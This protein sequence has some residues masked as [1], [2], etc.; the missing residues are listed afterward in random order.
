MC[1]QALPDLH[2]A[3][4]TDHE[5]RSIKYR[6]RSQQLTKA[7]ERYTREISSKKKSG[8]REI[9]AI[10]WWQASSLAP[11]FLA[12]LRG[13]D[14]AAV[15]ATKESEPYN[16]P[17]AVGMPISRHPPHRSGQALLTHPAPTLS[18]WRQSVCRDKDAQS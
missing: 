1:H 2:L 3:S 17:V 11:R 4:L 5:K 15:L 12:S 10:R 16:S 8:N 6:D 9:F 14:I 13:K 7:L 18:I